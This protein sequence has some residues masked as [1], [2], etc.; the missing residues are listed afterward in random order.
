MLCKTLRRV[1]IRDFTRM[2]PWY[3]LP[4]DLGHLFCRFDDNG[5][6][7]E[8]NAYIDGSTNTLP[9]IAANGDMS[10]SV[11]ALVDECWKRGVYLY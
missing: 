9:L 2:H 4:D 3:D 10:A 11:R 1:Q 7:V 6:L 5:N 8:L